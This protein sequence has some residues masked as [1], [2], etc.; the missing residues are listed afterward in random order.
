MRIRKRH[1]IWVDGAQQ[2]H[3][4]VSGAQ[5]EFSSFLEPFGLVP[6]CRAQPPELYLVALVIP[7]LQRE[8]SNNLPKVT[9]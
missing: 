9:G 8:K 4:L 7:I 2:E 1:L 6:L 3:D 5:A